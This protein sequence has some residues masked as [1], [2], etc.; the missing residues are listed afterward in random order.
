MCGGG[1]AVVA[2]EGGSCLGTGAESNG[3]E[4]RAL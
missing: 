4:A 1:E 2:R 3:G